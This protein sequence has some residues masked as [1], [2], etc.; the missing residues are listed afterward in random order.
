MR[1]FLV[2]AWLS[3]VACG[4]TNGGQQEDSVM[5]AKTPNDKAAQP[6]D[7]AA[8]HGHVQ[9]Q[10]TLKGQAFAPTEAVFVKGLL[11]G[12]AP[13]VVVVMSDTPE[14]CAH[15]QANAKPRHRVIVGMGLLHGDGSDL[16]PGTYRG[17][18][19]ANMVVA[20]AQQ[21]N[22]ACADDTT[23]SESPDVMVT[24]Y[25][26][27]QQLTA[28]FTVPF[29][30]DALMGTVHAVACDAPHFVENMEG[31]SPGYTCVD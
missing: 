12:V 31:F 6:H 11:G 24:D 27:G 15:L 4:P 13:G 3:C 7:A 29:G 17:D 21:A 19:D 9:V 23:Y 18:D 10:G 20:R 28:R 5:G 2:L 22:A 25:A 16:T 26:D 8:Y 1:R 14:L 30:E